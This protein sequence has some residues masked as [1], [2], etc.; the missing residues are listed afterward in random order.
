MMDTTYWDAKI[1]GFEAYENGKPI[2]DNPF[3]PVNQPRLF[4]AWA[5]SWLEA[6]PEIKEIDE[7]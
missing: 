5:E 4:D 7:E 1:L 6:S 2:T 3:D